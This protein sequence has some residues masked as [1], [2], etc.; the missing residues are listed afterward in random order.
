MTN[1]GDT[2]ALDVPPHGDT[3]QRASTGEPIDRKY[4]AR[5][6]LGNQVLERE[7]LELFAGQMPRYVEQLQ[8]AAST[9]EW[10]LAAHTIKGSA[11][12]VGARRLAN[13]AQLAERLDV[14]ANTADNQTMRRNAADAVADA[15]DEACRHI[16]SLFAAG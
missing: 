4:L 16:A 12:A 2:A 9:K 5:F 14:D 11:L 7:V 3:T 8:A 6:T 15:S 13:L 10:V 1:A